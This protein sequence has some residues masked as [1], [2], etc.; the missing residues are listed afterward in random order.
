MRVFQTRDLFDE[1]LGSTTKWGRTLEAIDASPELTEG[2]AYSV[3]DSLTYRRAGT[4]DLATSDFVGRRRYHLV[5]APTAGDVDVEIA[6]K[7][8][9]V[10]VEQYSDLTD[11]E[12]FSGS[13]QTVRIPQ[14]AVLIVDVDEAARIHPD[15]DSSAVVLHVTVEGATFHNK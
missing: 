9:L 8:D 10:P 12:R 6:A 3:G 14:D 4:A 2:V 15:P 5:V 11:R 13:G 1:V 7:G